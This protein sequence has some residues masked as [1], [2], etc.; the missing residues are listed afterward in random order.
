MHTVYDTCNN[1]VESRVIKV[2]G[3]FGNENSFN[4]KFKFD[5]NYYYELKR[6][7]MEGA[8]SFRRLLQQKKTDG[9]KKELTRLKDLYKNLYK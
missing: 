7:G 2:T 1:K 4:I 3:S 8:T 9:I 5:S 6:E